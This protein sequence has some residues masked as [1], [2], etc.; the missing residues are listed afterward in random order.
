MG[1]KSGINLMGVVVAVSTLGLFSLA[2]IA[3]FSYGLF[4]HFG[5]KSV[6]P[7]TTTNTPPSSTTA[8]QWFSHFLE[9][10]LVSRVKRRML[11][12]SERFER[13]TILGSTATN[14]VILEFLKGFERF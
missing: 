2:L 12:R 6:A 4:S 10:P 5:L 8:A 3:A 14:S 9:N 13:S 11:I 7:D 1:K